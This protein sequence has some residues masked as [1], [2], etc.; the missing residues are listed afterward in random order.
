MVA[1]RITLPCC[2]SAALDGSVM[3]VQFLPLD[4]SYNQQVGLYRHQLQLSEQ[5]QI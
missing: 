5:F 3:T 4:A 2:A 1:M